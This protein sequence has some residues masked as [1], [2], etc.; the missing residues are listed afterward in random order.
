MSI[1]NRVVKFIYGIKNK[2][3]SVEN[4]NNEPSEF[5]KKVY[6]DLETYLDTEIFPGC[7]PNEYGFYPMSAKCDK[8]DKMMVRI[9]NGCGISNYI[10]K[11]DISR[12]FVTYKCKCGNEVSAVEYA[13]NNKYF[14][15]KE[16]EKANH[17]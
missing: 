3:T 9:R 8:C 10:I 1:I 15:H 13:N 17:L 11:L 6:K 16:W 12:Q 2:D 7:K 5:M 14:W 4:N